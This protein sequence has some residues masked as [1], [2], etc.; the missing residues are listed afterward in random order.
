MGPCAE[1]VR[2]SSTY[3]MT[4]AISTWYVN[5]REWTR[6]GCGHDWSGFAAGHRLIPKPNRTGIDLLPDGLRERL[7]AGPGG[8]TAGCE[9]AKSAGIKLERGGKVFGE[10]EPVVTAGVEV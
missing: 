9:E 5:R 1:S 7:V 4:P 10:I 3:S 8:L 6:N 2:Q